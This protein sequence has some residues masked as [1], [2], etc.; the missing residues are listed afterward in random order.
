[1]YVCITNC[2]NKFV[3]TVPPKKQNID[4]ITTK[5]TQKQSRSQYNRM[6][7]A[8]IDDDLGWGNLAQSYDKKS[9]SQTQDEI[10]AKKRKRRRNNNN[11]MINEDWQTSTSSRDGILSSLTDQSDV[12]NSGTP[13]WISNPTQTQN[14]MGSNNPNEDN[15]NQF[16]S[17]AQSPTVSQN[18]GYSLPTADAPH[19]TKALAF[20][21]Q[22]EFHPKK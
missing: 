18:T 9:S 20:V 19:P 14:E 8:D 5:H 12:I 4:I 6:A 13:A 3:L 15:H 22:F 21:K 17:D 1:M 11:N 7:N 10:P 2:R 16:R